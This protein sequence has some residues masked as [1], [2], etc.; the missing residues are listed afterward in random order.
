MTWGLAITLVLST[1][2]WVECTYIKKILTWVTVKECDVEC[3]ALKN[4]WPH[5]SKDKNASKLS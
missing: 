5:I 2:F 3:V 4:V 1:Q